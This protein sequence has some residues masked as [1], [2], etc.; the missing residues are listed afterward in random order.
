MADAALSS[1]I[2]AFGLYLETATRLLENTR[3]RY[4]AEVQLFVRKVGDRRLSEL[5]PQVLLEWHAGYQDSASSTIRQKH[6]ALR[7]FFRF[8]E[9]FHQEP[10]AAVL[11]RAMDRLQ[12][13]RRAAAPARPE[14]YS[15]D[16]ALVRRLLEA[17]GSHPHPHMAARDRAMVHFLWAT[18]VR[19]FEL[20]GLDIANLDLEGRR[21]IVLGKGAKE[22]LVVFTPACRADLARWLECRKLWPA[23]C[24][25]VFLAAGRSAGRLHPAT[26]NAVIAR[27]RKASGIRRRLWTH[28]FRHNRITELLNRGMAIQDVAAYVGHSDVKTTMGYFHQDTSHLTE[29]YDRAMRDGRRGQPGDAAAPPSLEDEE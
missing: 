4:L 28:L 7:Q 18:G 23:S 16:Q 26:V 21:A 20:V 9:D 29:R 13:P 5:T 3:E 1:Y 8:L 17:A 22:R 11:L 19:R 2:Q 24:D 14:S 15:L 6:A 25:A 12:P 10:Q 27:V